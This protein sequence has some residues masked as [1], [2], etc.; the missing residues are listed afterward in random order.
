[1][2]LFE[3]FKADRLDVG[4]SNTEAVAFLLPYLRHAE[5]F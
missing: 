2:T 5:V 1:M 4:G 3:Y